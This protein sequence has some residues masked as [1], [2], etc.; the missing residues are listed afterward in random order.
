MRRLL[1]LHN[2]ERDLSPDPTDQTGANW[3]EQA[4]AKEWRQISYW[5][6]SESER[7]E[8]LSILAD[9]VPL[10]TW[11]EGLDAFEDHAP[12]DELPPGEIQEAAQLL[13]A[14]R[15][16]PGR[17]SASYFED[18]L[19]RARHRA[20]SVAG[21]EGIFLQDDDGSP[22]PIAEIFIYE[23]EDGRPVEL[24][25]DI[26][27][28]IMEKRDALLIT[29]PYNPDGADGDAFIE[30][31][32]RW[33]HKYPWRRVLPLSRAVRYRWFGVNT[34]LDRALRL[35]M[36]CDV[37]DA[38]EGS[39]IEG[40]AFEAGKQFE[41]LR[42][43]EHEPA[44]LRQYQIVEQ[45]RIHGA[46]GGQGEKKKE[47]YSIL[48]RLACSDE[49]KFA[50][51]S[52]QQALRNAKNLARKYDQTTDPKMFCD[53]RGRLLSDRWFKDWLASYRQERYSS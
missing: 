10:A 22:R 23:D 36:L 27:K 30:K 45:N 32:I 38:G 6:L 24:R 18:W 29:G 1:G 50:F 34:R 47:R 20:I 33:I 35:Y 42:W 9:R 28:A 40:F 31:H 41:A 13:E 25:E 3:R 7:A 43:K 5:N 49:R 21:K 4:A 44:A 19:E 16:F 8:L 37:L 48:N 53:Q 52:D 15:G 14:M 26:A 39:G 12:P 51:V 17:G 11:G 46:K 2:K